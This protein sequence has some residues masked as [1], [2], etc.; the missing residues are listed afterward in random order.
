MKHLFRQGQRQVSGFY[1][2]WLGDKAC[3]DLN[4]E[5]GCDARKMMGSRVLLIRVMMEGGSS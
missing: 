5:A 1:R 3:V 4:Q 2:C